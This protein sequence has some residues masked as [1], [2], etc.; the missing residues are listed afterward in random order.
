MWQEDK[1][2]WEPKNE[3]TAAGALQHS[4]TKKDDPDQMFLAFQTSD[5]EQLK[6][7]IS[8]SD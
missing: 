6:D 8:L 7:L 5:R 1:L 4:H 2:I 3:G